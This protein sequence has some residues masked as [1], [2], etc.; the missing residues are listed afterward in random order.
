[1]RPNYAYFDKSLPRSA[2]QVLIITPITRCFDT[3]DRNNQEANSRLPSGCR[4]NRALVETLDKDALRTWIGA[5]PA[6]TA[7]GR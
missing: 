6:A 4:A 7:S 1:V 2:P 3:T 5:A